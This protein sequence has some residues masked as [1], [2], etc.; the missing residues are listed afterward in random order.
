MKD[1]VSLVFAVLVSVGLFYMLD[2]ALGN[3]DKIS[4]WPIAAGSAVG[5]YIR[6]KRTGSPW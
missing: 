4:L 5:L 6:M 1:L 3:R 2:M